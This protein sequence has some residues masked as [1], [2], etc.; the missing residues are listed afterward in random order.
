MKDE[1]CWRIAAVYLAAVLCV[2]CVGRE[3]AEWGVYTPGARISPDDRYLAF[4]AGPRPPGGRSP[5][6]EHSRLFVLDLDAGDVICCRDLVL[7]SRAIAWEPDGPTRLFVV[8]NRFLESGDPE[9]AGGRLVGFT[10][11]ESPEFTYTKQIDPNEIPFGN[12]MSDLNWSPSGRVLASGGG[13]LSPLYLS[14]NDG[15]S[16]VFAK[17]VG[18]IMSQVWAD[19][20]TLV[21]ERWVGGNSTEITEVKVGLRGV[22]STRTVTPEPES[23]LCD[24]WNGRAICR[25][26]NR[27][28]LGGRQF[29][30][31]EHRIG[32]VLA[33]GDYVVVTLSPQAGD[34][35]IAICD[36]KGK[37]VNQW[38][39]PRT[40]TLMAIS[41]KRQC[42]Y[43]EDIRPLRVV[44]YSFRK[45]GWIR[46][47][48]K[49]SNEWP[50]PRV[51]LPDISVF[52]EEPPKDNGSGM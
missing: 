4:W 2:P 35:Q 22:E 33:D 19:D 44:A 52:D 29:F 51:R 3:K 37:T 43:L 9:L 1:R 40:T 5:W 31:S 6:T 14:F 26:K 38:P 13:G 46:Q 42:V 34:E 24:A 11:S 20:E 32:P 48:W 45:A 27:V 10:P 28:Y 21:V 47:G 12:T 50:I 36:R 15:E 41:S 16:F 39:V 25:G 7:G 18:S 30:E 49:V 17:E 23:H 8:E